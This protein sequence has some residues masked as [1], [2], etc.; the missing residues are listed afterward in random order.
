MKVLP[1]PRAAPD[2]FRL[3]RVVWVTS[4]AAGLLGSLVLVAL[5]AVTGFAPDFGADCARVG[6]VLWAVLGLASLTHYPWG[7]RWCAAL[8]SKYP[9]EPGPAPSRGD[10]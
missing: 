5:W 4:L 3:F 8:G 9:T 1:I 6:A 7:R 2:G 10:G